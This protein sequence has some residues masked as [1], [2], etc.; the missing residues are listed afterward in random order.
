MTAIAATLAIRRSGL[1]PAKSYGCEMRTKSGK[2]CSA[3]AIHGTSRC[4]SHTGFNA[5]LA[6]MRGGGVGR[7]AP[8]LDALAPFDVP[9]NTEDVLR[10]LAQTISDVR[11]GAMDPRT[12]GALCIPTPEP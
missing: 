6:G 4:F 3:P 9:K 5:R 1:D 7:V 10:L 2:P 8:H 11:T 12:A